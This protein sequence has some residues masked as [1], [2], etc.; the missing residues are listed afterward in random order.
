MPS[1]VIK[2][3]GFGLLVMNAGKGKKVCKNGSMMNVKKILRRIQDEYSSKSEIHKN[4]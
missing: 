4:G 2:F 3:I 1:A